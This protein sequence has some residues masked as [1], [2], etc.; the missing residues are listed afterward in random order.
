MS[1]K[2]EIFLTFEIRVILLVPFI[3]ELMEGNM[4]L[5]EKR[6]VVQCS[7]VQCNVVQCSVVQCI[8][9]PTPLCPVLCRLSCGLFRPGHTRL[10]H[11]ALLYTALHC[12]ILHTALH[13]NTVLSCFNLFSQIS[14]IA[15]TGHIWAIMGRSDSRHLA[16]PFFRSLESQKLIKGQQIIKL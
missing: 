12:F 16:I 8:M 3:P 4:V 1:S 15:H 11:A 5:C 13:C 14:S 9:S 10:V 6:S 7:V 2:H